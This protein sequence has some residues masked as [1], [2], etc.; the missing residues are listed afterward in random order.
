MSYLHMLEHACMQE[1]AP[2]DDQMLQE[3]L[4]W[5]GTVHAVVVKH[6]S[7]AW[8]TAADSPAGM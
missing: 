5:L 2:D 6:P 3:V 8:Q 7:A 4:A 1:L